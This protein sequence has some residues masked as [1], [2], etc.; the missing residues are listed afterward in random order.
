MIT[1]LS[2][3]R[4]EAVLVAPG[5]DLVAVAQSDAELPNRHHFPLGELRLLAVGG[6]TTE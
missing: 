4:G 6:I 2:L 3:E 5:H 1:H